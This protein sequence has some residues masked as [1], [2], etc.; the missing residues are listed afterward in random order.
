MSRSSRRIG[1]RFFRR[2]CPDLSLTCREVYATFLRLLPAAGLAGWRV[3]AE[4]ERAGGGVSEPEG[5]DPLPGIGNLL[6]F[7]PRAVR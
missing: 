7:R 2:K 1:G 5:R 4:A 6:M 3:P